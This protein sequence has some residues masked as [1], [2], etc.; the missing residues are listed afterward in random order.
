MSIFCASVRRRKYSLSSGVFLSTYP[1]SI[2]PRLFRLVHVEKF[3]TAH[4][5]TCSFPA[6]VLKSAITT[7]YQVLC[8]VY[9][10]QLHSTVVYCVL[11]PERDEFMLRFAD[12]PASSVRQR[13]PTSSLTQKAKI[14]NVL[15]LQIMGT[16]RA[17]TETASLLCRFVIRSSTRRRVWL[18]EE[19]SPKVCKLR[20]SFPTTLQRRFFDDP[21]VM[22]SR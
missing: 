14:A 6:F 10:L 3:P 15:P 19:T 7:V 11:S 4:L 2:F 12:A 20:L 16:S 18:D 13:S 8:T 1:M 9:T 5:P 17:S 21:A 22:N